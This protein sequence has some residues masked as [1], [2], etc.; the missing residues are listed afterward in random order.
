[1]LIAKLIK[2]SNFIDNLQFIFSF[3][4]WYRSCRSYPHDESTIDGFSLH[5]FDLY[6]IWHKKVGMFLLASLFTTKHRK[7]NNASSVCSR[8][9]INKWQ[10]GIWN[11][12]PLTHPIWPRRNAPPRVR[13]APRSHSL[14]VGR[15]TAYFVLVFSFY[16]F[17]GLWAIIY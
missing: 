4:L 9:A 1:M 10:I 8:A 14:R 7:A 17:G 13:R 16:L 5:Y 6:Y 11:S 15:V 3:R 12:I 2:L